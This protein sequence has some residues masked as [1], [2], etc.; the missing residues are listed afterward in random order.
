MKRQFPAAT[1]SA[2]FE[3]L[4]L[5][6]SELA[7]AIYKARIVV[8]GSNV[9]N[10]QG[11]YI[12]F[13]DTTSSPTNMC[14]I[15]SLIAYGEVSGGGS[16]QADAEA[17]YIQPRLPEDIRFYVRIP[18]TLMTD[19]MKQSVKGMFNPVF[20][21][22]RPLYGWSRS[23]NIWEK[24]LAETLQ[25]LDEATEQQMVQVLNTVRRDSSWKAVENWPQTL[26]TQSKR[27]SNYADGIC[28]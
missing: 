26:E 25:S 19:E 21:L 2:L 4:G 16:S 24:H 12:Y 15:R 18:Q 3:I 1:L 10:T 14:A 6:D 28:R 22:R 27:S 23:G 5:K 17:A 9:T 20:R 7:D 13:A 8:Q 11:D